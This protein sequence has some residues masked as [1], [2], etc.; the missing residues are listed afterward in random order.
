MTPDATSELPGISLDPENCPV[1]QV[2]DGIGDK[3]SILVMAALSVGS[4]RFSELRRD[5]PDV[6]QKMLTHTLRKLERD[7]LV[8]RI[9]TPT[10]PPRVDYRLRPLGQSLFVRLS[11]LAAWVIENRA[12][13]DAAR[14]SFDVRD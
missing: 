12:A 5:I 1:R 4:R 2:L 3:W 6:S 13:I 8:E 14:S 7:G 10:A 9:V 11:G